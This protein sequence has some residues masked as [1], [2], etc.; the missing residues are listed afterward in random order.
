MYD[1]AKFHRRQYQRFKHRFSSMLYN[2]E[3]GPFAMLRHWWQTRRIVKGRAVFV[4]Q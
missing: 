3:V 1:P 4:E 2:G